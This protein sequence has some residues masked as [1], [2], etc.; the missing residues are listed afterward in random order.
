MFPAPGLGEAPEWNFRLA[1]QQ[2]ATFKG[3][4]MSPAAA[5]AAQGDPESS[6]CL[7]YF[8]GDGPDQRPRETAA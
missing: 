3:T 4:E 1:Q 2:P 5:A 7:L 8:A 6:G